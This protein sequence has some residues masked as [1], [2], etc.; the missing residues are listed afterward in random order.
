MKKQNETVNLQDLSYL[1]KGCGLVVT[2]SSSELSPGI[3]SV[4]QY[5]SIV[6]IVSRSSE[7]YEEESTYDLEGNSEDQCSFLAFRVNF[8]FVIL[9]V[10]L[11]DGL[12]GKSYSSPCRF[13]LS[14]LFVA[15][16]YRSRMLTSS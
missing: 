13:S 5:S 16:I 4:S 8:L 14:F 15:V 10:M 3:E 12:Q 9:V 2:E 1:D 11:A 7:E 6:D